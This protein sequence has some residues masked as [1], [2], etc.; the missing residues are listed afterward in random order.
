MNTIRN[1]I[2]VYIP[3]ILVALFHNV[4]HESLHFLFANLFGEKVL[5]FRILTNGWGSSQVIFATPIELRSRLYWLVIAWAPAMLTTLVGYLVYWKRGLLITAKPLV[6]LFIWYFGALFMTIDPLYLGVFSWFIPGTD[7]EAA[8][9]ISL[10]AWPFRMA[11]LVVFIFNL[12][13]VY[14]WRSEARAN[15]GLYRSNKQENKT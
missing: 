13:L 15:L 14:R 3:L 7:V 6:N 5:E 1:R 11:A 4:M 10:P 12:N 9:L 8:T 2:C